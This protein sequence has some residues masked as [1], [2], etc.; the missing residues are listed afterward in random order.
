[1]VGIKMADQYWVTWKDESDPTA[2]RNSAVIWGPQATAPAKL[3][4]YFMAGPF[5]TNAAA[6]SYKNAIGTGSIIPK[7]GTPIIGG[8]TVPD[9]FHGLNLG[10]LALRVGEILLGIVLIGVGVAKLSGADN[11]ISSAVKVA[12]K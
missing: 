3:S 11:F 12:A 9:I 2:A 10:S 7:A 1:M 5:K 6:E 4:G 8:V